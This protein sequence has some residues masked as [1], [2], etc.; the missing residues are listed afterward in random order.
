MAQLRVIEQSS[1][2]VLGRI[3]LGAGDTV[4]PSEG[5]AADVFAQY[6][7]YF[8]SDRAT[9]DALGEGWSNGYVTVPALADA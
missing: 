4:E 8:D 7:K 1:G 9:F 3:T 6:R 2:K 5:T